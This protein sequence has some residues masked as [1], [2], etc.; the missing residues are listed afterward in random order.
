MILRKGNKN[1]MQIHFQSPGMLL[2]VPVFAVH[3]DTHQGFGKARTLLWPDRQSARD[4]GHEVLREGNGS[5]LPLPSS[6]HTP[7][8]PT[9][10]TRLRSCRGTWN[11]GAHNEAWSRLLRASPAL[12]TSHK[13]CCHPSTEQP[14]AP[15]RVSALLF[16][17]FLNH[18]KD[19]RKTKL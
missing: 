3:A 2:N 10:T 7:T 4:N 15:S 11:A 5:S 16:Q 12:S 9:S 13:A 19:K 8:G 17:I 18:A 1:P 14:R 6:T